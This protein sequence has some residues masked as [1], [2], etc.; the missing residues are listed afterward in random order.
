MKISVNTLNVDLFLKLYRSAGWDPPGRKQ[1]DRALQNTRAS[2]TAYDDGRAIGMVRLL[3]DGGM[4]F[5]LKDFVVLPE[6][7][8]RGVGTALLAA[9]QKYITDGLE[10][11]WAVSLELIS[12]KEAVTFYRKEGFEDRPCSWDG[13]GMFKMVRKKKTEDKECA[14]HLTA[15]IRILPAKE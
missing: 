11:N 15:D 8:G 9:V 5:Y 14:E 6:Y 4:S 2:F 10:E 13:P 7:R 12:T 1:T 3:G